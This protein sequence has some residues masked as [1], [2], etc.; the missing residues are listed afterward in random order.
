MRL[1]TQVLAAHDFHS[2]FSNP[3]PE[4][5]TYGDAKALIR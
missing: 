2:L 5:R 3:N 4:W 1:V